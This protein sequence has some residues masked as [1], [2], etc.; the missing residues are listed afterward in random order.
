M[1]QCDT[2]TDRAQKCSP[3]HS[4]PPHLIGLL[5]L[6]MNMELGASPSPSKPFFRFP[7]LAPGATLGTEPVNLRNVIW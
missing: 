4:D 5:A 1:F 6:R 7:I 2:A 3:A